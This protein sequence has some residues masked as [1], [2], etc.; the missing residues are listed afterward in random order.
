MIIARRNERTV[1]EIQPLMVRETLL[2]DLNKGVR[3]KR[4]N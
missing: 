3:I 4:I 2:P 1:L